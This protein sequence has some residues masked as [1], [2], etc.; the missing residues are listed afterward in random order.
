MSHTIT[1]LFYKITKL[2][3]ALTHLFGVKVFQVRLPKGNQRFQSEN[4]VDFIFRLSYNQVVIRR[5]CVK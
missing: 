3:Y 4:Y 2:F 5:N 1:K